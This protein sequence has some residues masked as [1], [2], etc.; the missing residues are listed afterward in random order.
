MTDRPDPFEL[1]RQAGREL[2]KITDPVVLDQVAT[3]VRSAS[4][5]EPATE[6]ATRVAS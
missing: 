5:T 3:I 1:G 6:P 2:P 4:T